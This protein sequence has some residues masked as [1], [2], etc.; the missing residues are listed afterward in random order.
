[1]EL[2]SVTNCEVTTN[3]HTGTINNINKPPKDDILI[4]EIDQPHKY[5]SK[6]LTLLRGLRNI[7]ESFGSKIPARDWTDIRTRFVENYYDYTTRNTVRDFVAAYKEFTTRPM[8]LILRNEFEP[9]LELEPFDFWLD[10]RIRRYFTIKNKCALI[11]T[12]MQKKREMIAFTYNLMQAKKTADSFDFI[13]VDSLIKHRSLL[14]TPTSNVPDDLKDVITRQVRTYFR[15]GFGREITLGG[16]LTDRSCYEA[17]HSRGGKKSLVLEQESMDELLPACSTG[18]LRKYAILNAYERRIKSQNVERVINTMWMNPNDNKAKVVSIDEPLKARTLTSGPR[19]RLLLQNLQKCLHKTLYKHPS[20]TF[21]LIGGAPVKEAVEHLARSSLDRYTHW[22]SGDYSAATDTL[23]RAAIEHV[24]EELIEWGEIPTEVAHLFVADMSDHI[25]EYP[26]ILDE[27]T[28]P[29]TQVRGQLMGCITSFPILCLLNDALY[30]YSFEHYP[31]E[32]SSQRRINGDDILFKC[33]ERGYQQ[34]QAHL[35]LIGFTPSPGKNYLHSHFAM[36]NNTPYDVDGTTITPLEKWNYSL[37][38]GDKPNDENEPLSIDQKV[39][40][41]AE[42]LRLIRIA[43]KKVPIQKIQYA[44]R[45]FVRY[46]KSF[47]SRDP[48]ALMLPTVMGGLGGLD[49]IWDTIT[50]KDRVELVQNVH[51]NALRVSI[52]SMYNP[53]DIFTR[54]VTLLDCLSQFNCEDYVS[55]RENRENTW[56]PTKRESQRVNPHRLLRRST[57]YSHQLCT[58]HLESIMLV[59]T[60]H[61]IRFNNFNKYHRIRLNS[62]F[63]RSRT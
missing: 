38:V 12:N 23:K 53:S 55:E 48:R 21:E 62:S 44:V 56:L 5:V 37:L 54:K 41:L 60:R 4:L 11:G 18:S 47:L 31:L 51:H 9:D 46:N 2:R 14:S 16:D 28:S 52:E 50:V 34:W 1:M 27:D 24:V 57:D 61:V 17:P 32:L 20:R 25:L 30:Q 33:T 19:D 10:Q 58:N 63:I 49:K 59:T 8:A 40:R 36:V 26:K 7:Y 43:H 39:Q 35:P 6:A 22:C 45:F 13:K 3:P 15:K 42:Q 29:I